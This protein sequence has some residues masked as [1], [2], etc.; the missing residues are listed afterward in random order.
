MASGAGTQAET[1]QAEAGTAEIRGGFWH[2]M[3]GEMSRRRD[4]RAADYGLTRAEGFYAR[5]P[6]TNAS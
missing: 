6:G 3:N 5:R 1:R 4:R 2:A